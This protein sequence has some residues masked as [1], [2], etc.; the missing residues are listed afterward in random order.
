MATIAS[1]LQISEKWRCY[2]FM[3][4]QVSNPTYDD[5]ESQVIFHIIDPET[6]I[7]GKIYAYLK[8]NTLPLDLS[9]NKKWNF[10]RQATWH[11]LIADILYHRGLDGT[12]LRCLECNE[13]E[14]ALHE[15]HEGIYGTHSSWLTLAKKL[16]HLGYY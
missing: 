8:D 12:L 10:I 14:I 1:L 11:T 7:Y 9:Q 16:L 3:V 13:S 5:P 6:S 2:E 4:E 15:I